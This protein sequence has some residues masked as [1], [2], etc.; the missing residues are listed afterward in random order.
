MAMTIDYDVTGLRLRS[1]IP[2]AADQAA[3]TG[4]DPDLAVIDGG[5]SEIPWE[6]PSPNVVAETFDHAG[7]P[8]YSFCELDDGTTV[9]RFYA[10][11]D[12][13]FSRD[14]HQV[15][16]HRH[17]EVSQAMAGLLVPG[18][19]VSY[20]LTM[21][22]HYVLHGSAVELPT[23]RAVG[24]VGPTARGKTTCAALLCAEG[25][26]LVTD[27]VLVVDLEADTPR[28]RR[29]ASALRL[30]TQQSGLV[31]RFTSAPTVSATPDGR[32]AVRPEH[33]AGD[34]VALEAIVM[35]SPSRDCSDVTTRRLSGA[36][37]VALL[38]AMPRIE[39]WRSRARVTLMFE[40]AT[41]LAQQI[42]VLEV[43][44]PWGPPFASDIGARLVEGLAR[45]SSE[46][47]V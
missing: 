18:N 24:F 26:G 45:A 38:M 11:A 33:L 43:R 34:D 25:C 42:P 37:A 1:D 40:Q 15:S 20:V 32:I 27:D 7:W 17:P 44:I 30:R 22:G 41:A 13:A 35:P 29:G 5:C 46:A 2:L 23:G 8:R 31:S 4:R 14:L 39:G 12:F 21:T 6:R 16:C 36:D 19:I 3:R 47:L 28:C 10:L 9:A